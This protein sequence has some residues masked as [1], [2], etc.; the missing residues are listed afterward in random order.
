MYGG[1]LLGP[2][3]LAA[4]AALGTVSCAHDPLGVKTCDAELEGAC[5]TLLGLHQARAL[6]LTESDL[7]AGTSGGV[8]RFEPERGGW[9]PVGWPRLDRVTSVLYVP[10]TPHRASLLAYS[11]TSR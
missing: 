9:F 4:A 8:L 1:T 11:G 6:A 7:Y 2:L 3:G 5:W 10:G